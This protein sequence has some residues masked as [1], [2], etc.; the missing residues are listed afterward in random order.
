MKRFL[1]MLMG[2]C[3]L[4]CAAALSACAQPMSA[5]APSMT[6]TGA[7]PLPTASIA[8][9]TE[10]L[11]S[12]SE[13]LWALRSDV[14]TG[15][16]Q[17]VEIM[18]L[19]LD[20][21]DIAENSTPPTDPENVANLTLT[22]TTMDIHDP[23]SAVRLESA[24]MT[25]LSLIEP[26]EG[27]TLQLTDALRDDAP[28]YIA[29]WRSNLKNFSEVDFHA[30]TASRD[31]FFLFL[32]ERST[33]TSRVQDTGVERAAYTPAFHDIKLIWGTH[34]CV[35]PG[36]FLDDDAFPD[37]LYFNGMFSYQGDAYLNVRFGDGRV[38]EQALEWPMLE[39]IIAVDLDGDGAREIVLMLDT[40][41]NGGAG[42]HELV[43]LK[44]DGD[45]YM[46][47][48]MIGGQDIGG[49]RAE[50]AREKGPFAAAS[51][52]GDDRFG[53]KT[54]T[55][56]S[57]ASADQDDLPL[58]DGGADGF[59]RAEVVPCG[60]GYA[61]KL[62]QY[63]FAS[64]HVDWLGDTVSLIRFDG[65]QPRVVSQWFEPP[66]RSEPSEASINHIAPERDSR[67]LNGR[68][69]LDRVDWA[70][71]LRVSQIKGQEG[72]YS[73]QVKVLDRQEK[74]LYTLK[75]NAYR[76][77]VSY[78]GADVDAD[79][80]QEVILLI[81]TDGAG[82][83]GTHGLVVLDWDGKKVTRLPV[84]GGGEYS[85][86]RVEQ[87]LLPGFGLE[88]AGVDS[89]FSGTFFV[90]PQDKPEDGGPRY[91]FDAKGAPKQASDDNNQGCDPIYNIEVLNC[92]DGQAIETRQY[93]WNV[94]H[95]N[96]IGD[97]VTRWVWREGRPVMVGERFEP[98]SSSQSYAYDGFNG[99][100]A[101]VTETIGE[102]MP[103]YHFT[104]LGHVGEWSSHADRILVTDTQSGALIQEIV[105]SDVEEWDFPQIAH[106]G[107]SFGLFVED[108]NFDGFKDMRLEAD[109]GNSG[110]KA[111][112]YWIWDNQ[113]KQFKWN[114]AFCVIGSP[115]VDTVAQTIT[116]P[117]YRD[118]ASTY[119]A[120][121]YRIENNVPV[122]IK[123]VQ[124]FY[125]DNV[126]VKETTRELADG[127]MR[128]TGVKLGYELPPPI[129]G[130]DFSMLREGYAPA[131]LTFA[132]PPVDPDKTTVDKE[133]KV[134][135]MT[136]REA[137]DAMLLC[138]YNMTGYRV[139]ACFVYTG[140]SDAAQTSMNFAM[141][142]G[143]VNESFF[144]GSIN[145]YT[146]DMIG[147]DIMNADSM[148]IE[149]SDTLLPAGFAD[150]SIEDVAR[151]F[152]GR[153]T[154]GRQPPIAW[155]EGS[156]WGV[157]DVS[158]KL[159]WDTGEFYEMD[160]PKGSRIPNRIYGPYPLGYAH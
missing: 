91:A 45:G 9:A 84:P 83:M 82:G 51:I 152:Y 31:A 69:Y 160:F 111:Y 133:R 148:R 5:A 89:G 144:S 70:S 136:L 94:S 155:T 36:I 158:V 87:R 120:Y 146:G 49:F 116:T 99:Q 34:Y 78:G 124:T 54:I 77:V 106:D 105:I 61:L 153:M 24:A 14:Y 13:A 115:V 29:F 20:G 17:A 3:L 62:R 39:Q 41:G 138:L 132:D 40:G 151:Y 86:V 88:L 11:P 112:Y 79:G 145:R 71:Q 42:I 66:V 64:S 37:T 28:G 95:I 121:T 35:M 143:D 129:P 72:S 33:L 113:A 15:A 119:N 135:V 58:T 141:S 60:N 98:L 43:E 114:E 12:T 74:T 10:K 154:Y 100:S 128:T 55:R 8:S 2:T 117:Q 127:E 56:V 53:G 65:G 125:P 67:G 22:L 7:T 118:N 126:H 73:I 50:V 103:A 25:A 147:L 19:C 23:A 97:W 93:M 63:T 101:T 109:E 18:M 92:G 26:L 108:V 131:K 46:D 104:A 44:R 59:Y 4:F 102:G 16:E 38:L 96:H 32:D 85:G 142:P 157:G 122:L 57:L 123:T 76:R 1:S 81:Q 90:P 137:A 130:V 107:A 6:E 30:I 47:A 68:L 139:E 21:V 134:P 52:Q 159:F 156:V 110:V 149:T 150:M 48:P 27:I 80:V 75:N 140:L